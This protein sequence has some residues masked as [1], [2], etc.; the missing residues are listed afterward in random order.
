MNKLKFWVIF[1]GFKERTKKDLLFS[2]T[3]KDLRIDYFSGRGAGG[4]N[5]NKNQNCVRLHHKDSG[6]IVT[7]QSHKERRSNIKE[8]FQNL[9]NSPKFKIWHSYKTM[10]CI[11]GKTV[12]QKVDEL[13]SSNNLKIEIQ[14]DGKW[15]VMEENYVCY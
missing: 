4:Q 6:A 2:I 9:V 10:E 8:A 5:R 11:E 14:E 7:G 3:K 12:E 13:L 15:V 1:M